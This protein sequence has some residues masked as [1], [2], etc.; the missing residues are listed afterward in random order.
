MWLLALRPRPPKFSSNAPGLSGSSLVTIESGRAW[1]DW[2]DVAA[3]S[4]TRVAQADIIKRPVASAVER[5][6]LFSLMITDPL[7]DATSCRWLRRPY[8]RQRAALGADT[9]RTDS[10]RRA[11]PI[12]R[13]RASGTVPLLADRAKGLDGSVLV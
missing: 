10:A 9:T 6:L 12:R 8:A 1:V 3:A 2:A 5:F 7:V 13:L 11:G 4:P